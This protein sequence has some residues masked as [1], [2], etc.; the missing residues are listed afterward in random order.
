MKEEEDAAAEGRLAEQGGH[1][2]E[3]AYNNLEVWYSNLKKSRRFQ[4]N[5]EDSREGI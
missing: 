4:N 1:V 5:R 2:Q 3:E